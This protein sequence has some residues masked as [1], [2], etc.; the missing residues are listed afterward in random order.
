MILVGFILYYIIITLESCLLYRHITEAP[1]RLFHNNFRRINPVLIVGLWLKHMVITMKDNK[2][3]NNAETGATKAILIL[4]IILCTYLYQISQNNKN[5]LRYIQ[6]IKLSIIFDVCSYITK[7]NLTFS[8]DLSHFT[9]S[10]QVTQLEK[11]CNRYNV[12]FLILV[13][14]MPIPVDTRLVL[15]RG[16]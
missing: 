7:F 2:L 4:P 9:I 10:K 8:N 16:A 14:G 1:M 13:I 3:N 15:R 6:F 5:I 12:S 11:F